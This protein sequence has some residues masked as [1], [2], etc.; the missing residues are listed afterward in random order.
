MNLH[1]F[2]A[3]VRAFMRRLT[4]RARPRKW[5]VDCSYVAPAP[6]T[7]DEKREAKLARR[8]ERARRQREG[9]KSCRSS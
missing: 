4:E 7:L 3:D 8:A 9:V 1:T 5:V 2:E 6:K